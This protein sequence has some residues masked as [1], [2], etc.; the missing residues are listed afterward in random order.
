M[1][2]WSER[3]VLDLGACPVL[4]RVP[5]WAGFDGAEQQ[6]PHH[7]CGVGRAAV[8]CAVTPLGQARI[9]GHIRRQLVEGGAKPKYISSSSINHVRSVSLTVIAHSR[10]HSGL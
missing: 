6:D 1:L 2:V 3:F 4:T 7:H 9:E 8:Y 5:V 10:L